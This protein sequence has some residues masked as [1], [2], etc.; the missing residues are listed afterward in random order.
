MSNRE[1][2]SSALDSFSEGS[3]SYLLKINYE[4]NKM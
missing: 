3:A 4:L 1:K 2:C